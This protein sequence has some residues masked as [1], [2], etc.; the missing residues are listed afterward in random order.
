MISKLFFQNETETGL[1]KLE[2][3]PLENETIK[4]VSGNLHAFIEGFLGERL[5]MV[6][7]SVLTVTSYLVAAV[8]LLVVCVVVH[9]M[10]RKVLLRFIGKMAEKTKNQWDDK[11]I[12]N[13]VFDRLSHIAPALVLYLFASLAFDW[14]DEVTS[15]VEKMAL[16]YMILMVAR[17]MDGFLSA[18][19]DI[20][21]DYD[22]AKNKPIKSYVQVGKIFLYIVT[23]IFLVAAVLGKD[24]S[25]ILVGLGGLSAVL[26]LVFKDSIMGLVASVQLTNND[27]VRRGDWI[28]VPSY[29]TDGDVIDI[30]LNTIKIRNFDKTIS[31]LPT[32]ALI[33]GAFQNWRG[34][35][36]SGGRRIKRA[37]HIDMNTIKFCD[38][39]MMEDFKKFELLKDYIDDKSKEVLTKPETEATV[40]NGRRLTNVG[41]F[42]A[43]IVAYLKDHEMINKELTF[44]V[45]QLAP[46]ELGLPIELYVF[47]SDKVWSNYEAIQGDI[48]DHLLA[49]LPEFG[50]KAFQHATGND[51]QK[52]FGDK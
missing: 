17:A 37:I 43:Y 2:E 24:P 23:G 25:G 44:L 16:A 20:Y 29:G 39:Q 11:I 33:N 7:G 48:F 21:R 19:V 12:K 52:A 27:M 30:G 35:Q 50:L 51:F 34:M 38:A 36:E 3:L 5:G 32:T 1:E 46:G 15:F 18:L 10:T 26:L 45:R 49:I 31:T 28:T 42:R 22:K 13:K 40:T 41:T 9:F 8:L 47:S 14:N 4:E 6:E